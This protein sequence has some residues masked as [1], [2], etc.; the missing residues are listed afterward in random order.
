MRGEHETR[1]IDHDNQNPMEP[2]YGNKLLFHIKQPQVEVVV[3]NQSE[4][5]GN[6]IGK[7][8]INNMKTCLLANSIFFHAK[9]PQNYAQI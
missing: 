7:N 4:N 5:F 6:P 1:F 8:K 9:Q 2:K 3:H